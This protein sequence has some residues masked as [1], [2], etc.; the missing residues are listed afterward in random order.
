MLFQE[1][2][3]GVLH[4]RIDEGNRKVEKHEQ[5]YYYR[6]VLKYSYCENCSSS[7]S[8][9]SSLWLSLH[10]MQPVRLYADFIQCKYIYIY[11]NFEAYS[12]FTAMR[13][14]QSGFC[15]FPYR[16]HWIWISG[17]NPYAFIRILHPQTGNRCRGPS[18]DVKKAELGP[19]DAMCSRSH[20]HLTR[21]YSVY[22]HVWCDHDVLLCDVYIS[23]LF[24][25][26]WRLKC[27]CFTTRLPTK[28][29]RLK[30]ILTAWGRIFYCVAGA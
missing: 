9:S 26:P 15:N 23:S 27:L 10:G 29:S 1:Q 22:L 30:N 4:K 2:L 5:P 16:I 12:L 3:F 19:G 14:A 21:S 17:P 25:Q 18:L 11:F 24:A 7:S 13:T 6:Y 28:V 8:S 20:M